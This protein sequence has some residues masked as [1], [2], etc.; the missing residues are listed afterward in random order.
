MRRKR[1]NLNLKTPLAIWLLAGAS[2]VALAALVFV[3]ATRPVQADAPRPALTPTVSAVAQGATPA[4]LAVHGSGQQQ[5][6]DTSHS[7]QNMLKGLASWYGG[8]FD[9]RKTAS[10]E[11]FD[12][13][14]MTAC[15]PTLPDRKS[16]V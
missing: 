15:H 8:V 11:R 2:S 4:T 13:Y 16:V 5:K 1:R 12:M 3:L 10:G 9:G 14:A 6:T 7:K